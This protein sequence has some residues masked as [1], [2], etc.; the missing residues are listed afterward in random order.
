[1]Y[2]IKRLVGANL[3]RTEALPNEL[4]QGKKNLPTELNLIRASN[5]HE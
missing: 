1:V 5:L 3:E 2:F 4:A